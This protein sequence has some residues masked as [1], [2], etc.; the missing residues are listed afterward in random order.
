MK[1]STQRLWRPI[2]WL[3]VLG[4]CAGTALDSL[5]VYAH[6]ERYP[7]PVLLGEAWWVPLLFGL[8][9]VAIGC[10]HPAVDPLLGHIRPP[11]RMLTSVSELAWLVLAYLITAGDL[12][13][14]AKAGLLIIIYF[15]F[16]LLSGRRWQN[17][18][19]SFVTAITGTLI[20]M[21]LVA[22]GIFSYLHPDILEVPVWLPLLYACASL[23]VG[24][25]GRTLFFSTQRGNYETT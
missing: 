9:T 17:L 25:L 3:F 10:S 15:N 13:S 4:A 8:A 12:A 7:M 24:D 6:V 16:W 2:L 20:E 1:I 22:T 5:H 21:V 11:Q 14:I 18:L 19:L 23:A